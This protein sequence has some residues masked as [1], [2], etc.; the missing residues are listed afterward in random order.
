[1]S[2]EIEDG[3]PAYPTH[4]NPHT[5]DGEYPPRY[6][7]GM[8]LRDW[9]AGQALIALIQNGHGKDDAVS[10]AYSFADGMLI[11]REMPYAGKENE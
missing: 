7:A 5:R 4:P 1:M 2:F 11:Q 10:F 8:T 9:F 6:S 3:G